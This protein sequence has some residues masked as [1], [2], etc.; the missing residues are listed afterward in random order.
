MGKK[1]WDW[2]KQAS[3]PVMPKGKCIHELRYL[4]TGY[5]NGEKNEDLVACPNCYKQWWID[6]FQDFDGSECS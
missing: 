3:R 6:D 1:D 2:P 5:R 4:V